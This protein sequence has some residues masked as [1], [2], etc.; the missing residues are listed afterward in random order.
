MRLAVLSDV[1]GNAYALQAVLADI[2]AAAP[3]AVYNL[4][5]T[6]WGGADP[7]RA[8]AEQLEH[9]PPTVRGNT[10]ETVAGWHAGRAE[11]WRDWVVGQLPPEV[12]GVLG[13]LPTTAQAAGG[14]LLLAH[15]SLHSAWDALFVG[16]SGAAATPEELREQVREW[17]RARVVVVGHT[18]REQV[19]CADGVT[20]VNVGPVSRQL[21]GDPAARWALLER[22]GPLWNVT[23]R[24]TAYDVEAAAAW[25]LAHCPDGEKEAAHLRRGRPAS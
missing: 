4:G 24:R 20:F 21:Q 10:D 19:A 12:P 7:A 22:R 17:P 6:V 5:D 16:R 3:D 23:L 18:H 8:W 15:G 11:Q 25:A 9:A 13:W 1:H 2:R 14:E